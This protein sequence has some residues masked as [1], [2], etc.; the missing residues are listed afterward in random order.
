M[1]HVRIVQGEDVERPMVRGLMV[2]LAFHNQ[3][4]LLTV[5]R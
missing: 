1:A 5:Q 3:R 4:D 2:E